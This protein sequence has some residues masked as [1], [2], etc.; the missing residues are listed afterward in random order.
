MGEQMGFLPTKP[1]IHDGSEI[2][3]SI[4][5]FCTRGLLIPGDLL[6]TYSRAQDI[7]AFYVS[8]KNGLRFLISGPQIHEWEYRRGIQRPCTIDREFYKEEDE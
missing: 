2:S 8:T 5:D 1:S 7:D 6:E 3:D 4:L